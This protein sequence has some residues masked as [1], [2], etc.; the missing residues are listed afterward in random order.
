M[1]GKSASCVAIVGA[2]ERLAA[3]RPNLSAAAF[4]AAMSAPAATMNEPAGK[5]TPSAVND[6]SA[7]FIGM[8]FVA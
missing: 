6:F 5:S 2:V 8:F 4:T 1:R 7:I 3:V